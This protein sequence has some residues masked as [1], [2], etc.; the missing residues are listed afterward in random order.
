MEIVKIAQHNLAD[1]NKANQPFEIIG[2][3][4][5]TFSDGI[6]TYTEELY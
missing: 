3:I 6:W 5:P 2:K 4:K 1:I